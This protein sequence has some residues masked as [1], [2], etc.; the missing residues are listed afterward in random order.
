[1]VRADFI[2]YATYASVSFGLGAGVLSSIVA[3]GEDVGTDGFPVVDM[4]EVNDNT[5]SGYSAAII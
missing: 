4:M 5:R 1:M 2:A 3:A